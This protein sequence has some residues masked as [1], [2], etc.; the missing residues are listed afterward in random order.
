M[1]HSAAD[2]E[3]PAEVSSSAL[4]LLNET[5]ARAVR[6]CPYYA[7]AFRNVVLRIRTL[8]D[9]QRFPLLQR[10]TVVK[11]G[12]DLLARSQTPVTVGMTGGTTLGD[13]SASGPLLFFKSADEV[14]V[15]HRLLAALAARMCPRPLVLH[16][17]NL[18]H[19]LEP[20]GAVEG[21]FQVPLERGHH[22][23]TV[24]SLLRGTFSFE[25]FTPRVTLLAGPLRLLKALTILCADQG[26]DGRDFAIAVVA[27]SSNHLT[28][29]WRTFLQ[30]YWH[31]QV[32]D[33]Y[34]MSE[35][36]GLHARRCETCGHLHCS[37]AVV[38][39]VLAIDKD[40]PVALGV[41]RLVAT[42]LY[43]LAA[44]QPMIRYDTGDL[45]EVFEPCRASDAQSLEFVG[46]RAQTVSLPS[47]SAS[48][49]TL[50]PVIVNDV[51]DTFPDV[52]VTQFA[53]AQ[54][55]GIKTSIGFLKW[56]L[57]WVPNHN[58]RTLELSVELR[59]SPAQFRVASDLLRESIRSQVL[60]RS[61]PLAELV[62]ANELDFLVSLREPGTTKLV[63]AV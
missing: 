49:V 26:L 5:I 7:E 16:L 18:G 6:E 48:T 57:C 62:H 37:G 52:A 33:F 32:D 14:A 46:R 42:S 8:S 60:E 61:A 58:A 54:Q 55:L 10:E 43:P 11:R 17:V 59:W 25:G 20:N 38:T 39:E 63:A 56:G 40:V 29:R 1:Q 9:L 2:I 21:C 19:G 4:E 36:P 23:E 35:V 53:F 24:M 41:G 27:S 22:V 30:T 28:S 44:M 47:R 12:A 15:K 51:L 31:A 13:G 3:A 50:P 45:V 34:G